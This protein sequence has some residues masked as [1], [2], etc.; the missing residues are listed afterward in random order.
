MLIGIDASRAN[1]QERTGV[2]EYAFQLI[3]HL[4]EITPDTV[5]VVLYTDK[6]LLGKLGEL[7]KNWEEKILN[8]PFRFWTQIRLSWE[9]L[10]KPPEVL[11]IPAHVFPIIHPKKTVMTVHDIAAL[12]FPESYNWFERWYSVRARSRR[13]RNCGV[14]LCQVSLRRMN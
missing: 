7:P 3:Q 5:Q 11:F 10:V 6:K 9:M 12:K 14:L 8:W 2:E 1:H 4:K 13:W